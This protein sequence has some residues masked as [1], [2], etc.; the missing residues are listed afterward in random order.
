MSCGVRVRL[1]RDAIASRLLNP[2]VEWTGTILAERISK[3]GAPKQYLARFDERLKEHPHPVPDDDYLS[4]DEVERVS[5]DK[6]VQ[7]EPYRLFVFTC[8]CGAE[9]KVY[10]EPA[11]VTYSGDDHSVRC[12]KCLAR[13]RVPFKPIRLFNR[14]TKDGDVWRPASL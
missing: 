2:D 9:L 11:L 6:D 13:H 1:T 14:E 5:M 12:P 8:T 7:D 10:G 4:E 3:K